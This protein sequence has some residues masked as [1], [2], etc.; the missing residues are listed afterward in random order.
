MTKSN[1]PQNNVCGL[2]L[3]AEL[4]LDTCAVQYYE[5]ISIYC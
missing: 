2:L 1:K 5:S 4:L 3:I